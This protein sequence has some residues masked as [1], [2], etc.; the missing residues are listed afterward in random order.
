MKFKT[1]TRANIRNV[2]QHEKLQE[3][4]IEFDR[5]A[6]GDGRYRI[7]IMV[8]GRRIH[9]LVGKELDGTTRLHAEKI[10][11]EAHEACLNLPKGRK[12]ALRFKEAAEQYLQK[13]N[14][15]PGKKFKE[16]NF[17]AQN[18]FNSFF[19]RCTPRQN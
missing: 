6:N 15:D 14:F 17:P 18:V 13:T 11:N 16:K 4:G 10:R 3:N 8:D 2:G 19:S 1:L 9:R 12:L 5:L 7:N